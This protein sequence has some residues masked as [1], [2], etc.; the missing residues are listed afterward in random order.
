MA[1]GGAVRR[2]PSC[3]CPFIIWMKSPGV[4]KS[5]API[6]IP[7][8]R[9]TPMTNICICVGSVHTS[10]CGAPE[11]TKRVERQRVGRVHVD[12]AL[13]PHGHLPLLRIG[14][15]GIDEGRPEIVG[16]APHHV[17]LLQRIVGRVL[18]TIRLGEE[19][20]PAVLHG[21]R[22]RRRGHVAREELLVRIGPVDERRARGEAIVVV[23]GHVP[24][25]EQGIVLQRRHLAHEL[26]GQ[27]NVRDLVRGAHVDVDLRVLIDDDDLEAAPL[28]TEVLAE[29]T[30]RTRR[31]RRSPATPP[32]R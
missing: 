3:P 26:L 27:A 20:V 24:L 14:R 5:G 2:G 29:A 28:Q 17:E 15:V 4:P 32:C 7:C 22:G 10:A 18:A 12:R 16:H 11:Q 31:G 6:E 9:V 21:V 30:D 19:L 1:I 13:S 25:L 8:A 23:A